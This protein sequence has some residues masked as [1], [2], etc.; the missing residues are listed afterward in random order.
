MNLLCFDF[1]QQFDGVMTRAI[2]LLLCFSILFWSPR[3]FSQVTASLF[4]K[5]AN[6]QGEPLFGAS[7]YLEGTQLGAQ[8]D[9]DGNYEVTGIPPGSYNLIASYL[10][11]KSQTK[12]NIIVRSKGT[13]A[14][15][16]VLYEDSEQLEEVVVSNTNQ[17]SRPRETPLSTQTLSA[18]EIATYPG[19]NNDV[20]RV[21]QTPPA[22]LTPV[23]NVPQS[24][25]V[26]T[27]LGCQ[28]FS[29]A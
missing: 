16:F 3:L 8:T 27:M 14:Y 24:A 25:S 26:I 13:L 20:V 19:S 21:A 10:G 29:V 18:V 1:N 22:A 15:N 17:I 5:V 6:E 2:P 11:Y 9:F 23:R 7:V 12:Y 4:G 28:S